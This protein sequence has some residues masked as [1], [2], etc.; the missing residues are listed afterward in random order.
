MVGRRSV[1]GSDHSIPV[2]NEM[3]GGYAGMLKPGGASQLA[4]RSILLISLIVLFGFFCISIAVYA[5]RGLRNLSD[6]NEMEFSVWERVIENCKFLGSQVT[7]EP[8]PPHLLRRIVDALASDLAT[9]EKEDARLRAMMRDVDVALAFWFTVSSAELPTVRSAAVAEDVKAH[10]RNLVA[11]PLEILPAI[12]SGLDV[13]TSIN[14]QSRKALAPLAARR[15]LLQQALSRGVTIIWLVTSVMAAVVIAGIAAIWIVLL[16]PPLGQL[17]DM[18]GKLRRS[19]RQL[20]TTLA[21]IGDAV[22]TTDAAF[23]IVSMNPVAETMTGWTV[24]AARRLSLNDVVKLE[25]QLADS[26]APAP[27]EARRLADL[28]PGAIAGC[29]LISRQGMRCRIAE[30]V[31]PL[32]SG[33][34]GLQGL[35]F[36]FR[37]MTSQF[38]L[39][40]KL[41]RR[42]KL[43][44][45]GEL[46]SGVAHDFN[47][48]LGVIIGTS[49]LALR[50]DE[51]RQVKQH[52]ESILKVARTGAS[53]TEKLLSFAQSRASPPTPESIYSV[54]QI[55]AKK[56]KELEGPAFELSFICSQDLVAE[57]DKVRLEAAL[58]HVIASALE[59]ISNGDWIRLY[60]YEELLGDQRFLTV[61][62]EDEGSIASVQPLQPLLEEFFAKRAVT[63]FKGLGIPMASAFAE[64]AGGELRIVSNPDERRTSVFIRFPVY[65]RLPATSRGVVSTATPA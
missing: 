54:L 24:A 21:S 37:D 43:Q 53:L 61:C 46:S 19:E 1:T 2:A 12:V 20:K 7:G 25:V 39:Q 57:V 59:A 10:V 50:L 31:A 62:V 55:V 41:D 65:A 58:L 27:M 51:S 9:L 5:H 42:A 33:D 64:Q 3:D 8:H 23:N 28:A 34:S 4:A 45:M 30:S 6:A 47:N 36:V 29:W 22:I 48:C 38:D 13:V 44:A 26:P 11:V 56:A 52:F 16:K 60:A 18:F 17:D 14:I 32:K 49:S 40:R 35:V 63:R 15:D